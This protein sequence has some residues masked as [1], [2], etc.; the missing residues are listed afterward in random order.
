MTHI[1]ES[2]LE[3]NAMSLFKELDYTYAFGQHITPD[4]DNLLFFFYSR[5]MDN[6]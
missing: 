1:N 4:S 2:T 6:G 3:H 5:P